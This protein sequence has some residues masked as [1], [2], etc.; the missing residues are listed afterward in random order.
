MFQ[1]IVSLR[2]WPLFLLLALLLLPLPTAAQNGAGDIDNCCFVDRQCTTDN[3]WVSGYW[4]FQNNEC[5][6]ASQ[7]QQPAA[8]G[9]IDNCC[10]IDWLCHA[11]EEWVSGYYAFQHNYCA[12]SSQWQGVWSQMRQPQRS[13]S[14][15]P[16]QPRQQQQHGSNQGTDGTENIYQSK[17][18]ITLEDGTPVVVV[19]LTSWAA[20]WRAVCRV[21][22][23]MHDHPECR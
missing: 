9:E 3:E 14:N 7:P 8:A 18:I 4:A 12:A 2:V 6:V 22:P 20:Y 23:D 17:R 13:N 11:D 1:R 19:G 10:F 15:R 5:T 16:S 21:Y